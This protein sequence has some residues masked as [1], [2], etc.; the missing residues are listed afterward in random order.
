MSV[1][2]LDI[3]SGMVIGI[4]GLNIPRNSI[5]RNCNISVTDCHIFTAGKYNRMLE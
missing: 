2:I 5:S 3:I 1:A 4:A